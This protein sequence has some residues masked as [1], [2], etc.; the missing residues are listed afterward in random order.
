MVIQVSTQ[1]KIHHGDK[2]HLAGSIHVTQP[3]KIKQLSHKM[4]NTHTSQA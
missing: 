3:L 4:T 1:I 2:H